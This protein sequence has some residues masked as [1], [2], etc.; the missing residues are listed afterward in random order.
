MVPRPE[1]RCPAKI[2]LWAK[3]DEEIEMVLGV[4]YFLHLFLKLTWFLLKD[5]DIFSICALCMLKRA[6]ITIRY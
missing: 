6:A 1:T 5:N 2:D 3:E 4:D